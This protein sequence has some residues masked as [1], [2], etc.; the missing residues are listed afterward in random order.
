[1]SESNSGTK[2]RKLELTSQIVTAYLSRNTVPAGDLRRLIEQIYASLNDPLGSNDGAP[3]ADERGA[4]VPLRTSVPPAIPIKQSITDDFIICLEDG[5]K[6]KSMKRHLMAKYGL[7]PERYREK[8]GLPDDYPMT[9]P[10]YSVKRSHLA[11]VAG[12]GKKA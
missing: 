2:Q 1:M 12:L 10:N 6:F 3:L 5:K 8:W 9:A 11:R 7:T 4:G